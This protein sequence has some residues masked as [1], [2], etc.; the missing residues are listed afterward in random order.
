MSP[1]YDLPYTTM[2]E[3]EKEIFIKHVQSGARYVT[4]T[5]LTSELEVYLSALPEDEAKAY[6]DFWMRGIK[7][8]PDPPERPVQT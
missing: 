3:E 1:L 8:I 7:V 5:M 2:T 6:R 4:A